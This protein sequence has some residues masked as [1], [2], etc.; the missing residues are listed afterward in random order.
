MVAASC[1]ENTPRAG[2]VCGS[3]AFHSKIPWAPFLRDETP[4]SSSRPLSCRRVFT[5][6]DH[7]FT[8]STTGSYFYMSSL[9]LVLCPTWL[10]FQSKSFLS[11]TLTQLVY[12]ERLN[13]FQQKTF[14]GTFCVTQKVHQRKVLSSERLSAPSPQ[15][16][17]RHTHLEAATTC[18]SLFAVADEEPK[19]RLH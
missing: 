1:G 9:Q 17:S 5:T 14:A 15:T 3:A 11:V 4:C 19:E 8:V 2:D 7:L 12:F 10:F 18:A 16:R 13:V 6:S